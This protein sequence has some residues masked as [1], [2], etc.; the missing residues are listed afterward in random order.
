M[1]VLLIALLAA[2]SYAQTERNPGTD[3]ELISKMEDVSQ[4]MEDRISKL[5]KFRTEYLKE[6]DERMKKK[7]ADPLLD[8]EVV[9]N[10]KIR[11][12]EKD[13]GSLKEFRKNWGKIDDAWPKNDVGKTQNKLIEEVEKLKE[14]VKREGKGDTAR[15]LK[16]PL[17][18]TNPKEFF[19]KADSVSLVL[20]LLFVS[21]ALIVIGICNL[22]HA[23]CCHGKHD[24]TEP[25]LD[26]TIGP[27]TYCCTP[28]WCSLVSITF[29]N[30]QRTNVPNQ[31]THDN[32]DVFPNL[33]IPPNPC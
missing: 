10:E 31:E 9:M 27:K 14:Q 21:I 8:G 33:S 11:N 13:I 17:I 5:E 6:N 23:C 25:L 7:N 1:R 24:V 22:R 12:L 29:A 28:D 20:V 3:E 4:K 32:R 2:I 19:N 18:L 16:I 30:N 15:L 26:T